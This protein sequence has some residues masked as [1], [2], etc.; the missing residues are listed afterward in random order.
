M[1][2]IHELTKTYKTGKTGLYPLNYEIPKGQI[3]ALTGGNGAGKS[4][5]IKLLTG[6]MKPTS[7]SVKW[8]GQ[9]FSYMPD[10]L[11]FP[12]ELTAFEVMK[13]LGTLK[14]AE[15]ASCQRMLQYV[16]LED[17]QHQRIG[18]FSKGMKQRLAF[19]QTLLSKEDILILDEPTNGLDPYWIK[20]MKK[21]LLKEKQKGKTIIFSTHE[22]SFAESIADDLLFFYDGKTLIHDALKN[23]SDSSETLETIIVRELEKFVEY[24]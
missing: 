11:G 13:L 19:A 3:V 24:K 18:T 6:I 15:S 2:V 21:C 20:W 12:E 23:L 9:S 4:T 1:I 5:L 14:A 7:G 16:G 22:L 10:D 8:N 17:V